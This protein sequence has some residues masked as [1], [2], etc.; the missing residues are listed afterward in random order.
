MIKEGIKFV[1]AE[2][3]LEVLKKPGDRGAPTPEVADEKHLRLVKPEMPAEPDSSSSKKISETAET[4]KSEEITKRLEQLRKEVA[5]LKAEMEEAEKL[6]LAKKSEN[7]G[8]LKN[9]NLRLNKKE[10][11]LGQSGDEETGLKFKYEGKK[12]DYQDKLSELETLIKNLPASSLAD[13]VDNIARNPAENVEQGGNRGAEDLEEKIS[14]IQKEIGEIDRQIESCAGGNGKFN[15]D[16]LIGNK[17][18][19]EKKADILYAIQDISYIR[20]LIAGGSLELYWGEGGLWNKSAFEVIEDKSGNIH[21]IYNRIMQ[22]D[23]EL[24]KIIEPQGAG[25]TLNDWITR[26]VKQGEKYEIMKY[27]KK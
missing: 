13:S 12:R 10:E 20:T 7:A 24:K 26:I 17:Q 22:D 19:A 2:E 27:F 23:G 25:E 5:Q 14:I 3:A 4:A 16:E 9:F 11:G 1:P 15:I 8:F 18:G 21:T 6:Y